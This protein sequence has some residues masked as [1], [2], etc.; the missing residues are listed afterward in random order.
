MAYTSPMKKAQIVLL[1]TQSVSEKEVAERYSVDR[2]T[3]NQIIKRYKESK[4]FYYAKEKSGCP[5]KFTTLDI[6]IAVRILASTQAH[7]IA[8]LQKDSISPIC[9]LIQSGRDSPNVG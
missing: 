5:H 7:D 3:V 9:M 8:N 2:S 4:D 6:H 1:R